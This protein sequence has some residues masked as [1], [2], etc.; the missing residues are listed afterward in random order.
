MLPY[1]LLQGI[2]LLLLPLAMTA[3]ILSDGTS[4]QHG[5]LPGPYNL[6]WQSAGILTSGGCNFE[7]HHIRDCY[8]LIL[9]SQHNRMLD[10]GSRGGNRQR[11]ELVTSPVKENESWVYTWKYFLSPETGSSKRFFHIMQ[12]LARREKG[13]GGP[14]LTLS[15]YENELRVVDMRENGAAV[16]VDLEKFKGRSTTHILS[17]TFGEHGSLDY[18]IL[19]TVS[20]ETILSH[21]MA[22]PMIGTSFSL[23]FGLYRMSVKG[24]TK[25]RAFVGDFVQ[26]KI[27]RLH[28]F[29]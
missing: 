28:D 24:Q 10:P 6:R 5:V 21:S 20:G 19:D 8:Q 9:S 23:K 17:A 4:L 14:M 11:I 22:R 18:R 12:L 13:N 2:L 16:T 15:L 29:A 3:R 27:P 25:A 26:L 7:K 1:G